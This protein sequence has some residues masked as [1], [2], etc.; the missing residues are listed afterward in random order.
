MAD[1]T[2]H[3]EADNLRSDIEPCSTADKFTANIVTNNG[4]VSFAHRT[5]VAV[6]ERNADTNHYSERN[7]DI[8]PYNHTVGCIIQCCQSER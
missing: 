3:T 7:A 6:C 5:C 4:T 8:N 2:T 1:G